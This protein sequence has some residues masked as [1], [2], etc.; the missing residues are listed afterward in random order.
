MIVKKL[1]KH[2]AL[3]IQSPFLNPVIRYHFLIA[4]YA[5]GKTSSLTDAILYAIDY[6]QGCK[7]AEGKNVKIGVY[8]ITLTFLTK[9]LTGSLEQVFR[10]TESIYRYQRDKNII[11][12]GTVELQLIGIENPDDIYGFDQAAA[13][14]DELD[15][16]PTYKAV[17]AVKAI[18]DRCRQIIKNKRPPYIQF[19]TTSQGLKGTYQ[20]VQDFRKKGIGYV[21]IRGATKDNTYLSKEYISNMYKMYTGKERECLLEGKFI[22]IDSG[23]VFPDYNP[24]EHM[25]TYDIYNKLKPTEEVFIGQDFNCLAKGT[26]VETISGQVNIEDIK[27]G[28]YV[29]TRKGYK[30]VLTT[31]CKGI[32][33]VS[34]YNNNLWATDDHIAVTPEGD[35]EICKAKKF[36]SLKGCSLK[37]KRI[38]KE[39][40]TTLKLLKELLSMEKYIVDIQTT[41]VQL[42]LETITK[43]LVEI[44]STELSG[45]NIE[46]KNIFQ[47]ITSTTKELFWI[48]GLRTCNNYLR[49]NILGCTEKSLSIKISQITAGKTTKKRLWNTT[50]PRKDLKLNPELP[51]KRGRTGRWIANVR[52]GIVGKLSRLRLRQLEDVAT[53]KKYIEL[54]LRKE[55]LIGENEENLSE[56]TLKLKENVFFVEKCLQGL[57]RQNTAK[58]TEIIGS[59]D[60]K[61]YK[62]ASVYD[63]EVEDAHEFFANG[64]LVHNCGFNKA[65]AGVVRNGIIIAIKE[66]N[67]PDIRVAP[68]VFRGDFP[69]NPI[70]W[71][72]DATSN[73]ILTQFRQ[74]LK[75]YNIKT[76]VRRQNPLTRDRNFAINKLFKTGYLY[77]TPFCKELSNDLTIHQID[78]KSGSPMKG[79]GIKAPDHNTD[80]LSYLVYHCL[81]WNR[82]MKNVY[83]NMMSTQLRKSR[84]FGYETEEDSVYT[85]ID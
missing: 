60:K 9:T 41:T 85:E 42:L 14:V 33:M 79:Q 46:A 43:L 4:G 37:E 29:L 68:E 7:D 72:P 38:K 48:T 57:V 3:F 84:D 16:L 11:T 56:L 23:L 69:E 20:S 39:V 26:K 12:V 65:I 66:Y 74:E 27:V 19:A 28:D 71:I 63:I 1:L 55:V 50:I 17:D 5:A 49:Q 47:N 2:Q 52:V 82:Q 45:E 36:Y 44:Y 21:I 54:N 61:V 78:P 31:A 67:F 51:P 6:F 32:K 13:F 24:A 10:N 62:K 81:T 8:G 15:E 30:K 64:I 76:V 34:E 25:M 35:T 75:A 40:A 18:N 70:K 73:N 80:S 59:V 53:V 77:L 58:N 83:K 22:S